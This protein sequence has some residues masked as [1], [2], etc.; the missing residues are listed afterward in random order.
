VADTEHPV[1]PA[2]IDAYF[3]R[4]RFTRVEINP[5]VPLYFNKSMRIIVADANDRNILRTE[6]GKLAPID[7]VIGAP[8]RSLLSQIIA[9]LPM[10]Q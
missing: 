2:E 10:E 8:E 9:R 1:L 7:L 4:L 6:E 5:D 3:A